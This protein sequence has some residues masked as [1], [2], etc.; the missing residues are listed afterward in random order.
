MISTTNG[1]ILSACIAIFA[2]RSYKKG[3][4]KVVLGFAGFA[5]AYVVS[6]IATPYLG[7]LAL[8]K[9]PSGIGIFILAMIAIFVVVS[10][11]VAN[12]PMYMYP[13]L[14]QVSLFQRVMGA[15]LG[16]LTGVFCAIILIW[17]VGAVSAAMGLKSE[18]LKPEEAESA[19]H[20]PDVL[21]QLSTR[22]VSTLVHS[23]VSLLEKDQFKAS[24]TAAFVSAPHVFTEAFANISQSSELQDFWAD[25][26]SQFFMGEADVDQLLQQPA[27]IALVQSPGIRSV[28]SES[29]PKDLSVEDTERY[30]AMQMSFV[31]RRMRDLRSD[32]R[33]VAILEDDEVKQLIDKKN[34]VALLANKKIQSLMAI[35]MEVP[36]EE[37]LPPTHVE[38]VKA[39][40][41]KKQVIYKWRDDGG[42]MR[43]TDLDNTPE[44]KRSRAEKIVH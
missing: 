18:G 23:G 44:N 15:V 26:K 33:V 9:G 21:S 17:M 4:W 22:I 14:R 5:C 42:K 10:S 28:L 20:Q 1:V 3:V 25:G 11:L 30:F 36:L 12:V 2:L 16:S 29:T 32:A 39:L 41:P 40:P 13:A 24:A 19:A 38:I 8:P 43:Y 7:A 35:V 37:A 34:P 6:Y 27:F 31:W